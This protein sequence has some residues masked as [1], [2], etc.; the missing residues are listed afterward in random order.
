L[1]YVY[2]GWQLKLLP[3]FFCSLSFCDPILLILLRVKDEKVRDTFLDSKWNSHFVD[4][5]EIKT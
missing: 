1:H 4:W 2:F 3:H 5:L